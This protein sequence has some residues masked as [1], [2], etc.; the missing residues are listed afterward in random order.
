[1]KLILTITLAALFAEMEAELKAIEQQRKQIESYEI[2]QGSSEQFADKIDAMLE[3]SVK[4]MEA[5][6]K[7]R[8]EAKNE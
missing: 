2:M 1:M 7:A 3:K 4:E 5:K 6:R 8:K